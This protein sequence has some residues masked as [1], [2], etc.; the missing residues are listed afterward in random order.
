MKSSKLRRQIAWQAARLM[1]D[2]EESEYYRA[3]MKAAR[4]IQKGWVKPADLPSNAEIRDEIQKMAQMIEGDRRDANLREMRLAA[5][6][7]MQL[8]EKFRPRI[9]GS[10]LTGHIRQGSDIDLHLFSDSLQAILS[11]LEFQNL[12]YDVTTKRIRKDGEEV[13]YRHIHIHDRFEF[14]LTVYPSKKQSYVF[15]TSITGKAIERASI[16][17]FEEFLQN[18]YPDV[19]LDDETDRL[20]E[21]VDPFQ[22]FESLLLPL[23]NVKQNPTYHPEGDALYHSLQVYDLACDQLPYDEEFLLAAI[24]HDVG[25]GIEPHD[26]VIS[27]LQEL[28]GFITE[29]T[30]WLI[31]NHMLAHKIYDGSIG[32]RKWRRL[33]E[34]ESYDELVLLG[35]CDRGGRQVGVMT[36]TLED[37]LEYIRSISSAFG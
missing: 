37:A 15:K 10:V 20:S 23:E 29:R 36:T 3:K 27:G 7:L 35:E 16:A 21:T 5:F 8:L 19:N 34:N 32:A 2:R 28:E 17:Q 24:L 18:E 9:I 1:Y 12:P 33:R 11:E 26:H 6:Y 31:A 30:A 14:E 13:T 25:K 22:V 4:K